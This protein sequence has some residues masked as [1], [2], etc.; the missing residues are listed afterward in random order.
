MVGW[1]L[2]NSDFQLGGKNIEEN[3]N[4]KLDFLTLDIKT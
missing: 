3:A 4:E 1:E 2:G